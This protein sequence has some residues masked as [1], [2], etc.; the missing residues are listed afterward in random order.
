[1]LFIL[2]VYLPSS[3]HDIEELNEYLDYLW[4]LYDSLSTKCFVIVI[5]DLNG[6]FGNALGDRGFYEPNNRGL[7]LL[8]FANYFNLYPTNL[9]QICRGPLETFVSHCGRYKSTIDYIL[10]PNSLS[11][12]IASCK[13][14]EHVIRSPTNYTRN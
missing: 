13:I 3:S 12:S 7:K 4:A 5:G 2:C 9:L 14:F 1:M 11:D 8:D 10:L 6:D